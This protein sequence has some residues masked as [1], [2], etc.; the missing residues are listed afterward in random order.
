MVFAYMALL[1]VV[2]TQMACLPN[3]PSF[4]PRTTPLNGGYTPKG[5]YLWGAALTFACK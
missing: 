2:A 5:N 3:R 4:M 1:W